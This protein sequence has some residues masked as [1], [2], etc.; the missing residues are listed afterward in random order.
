MSVEM[1]FA[2][3]LIAIWLTDYSS[4]IVDQLLKHNDNLTFENTDDSFIFHLTAAASFIY[5]STKK[6]C[7]LL[8]LHCIIQCN[9]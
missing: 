7:F 4:I 5:P 6:T 3:A 2:S 1:D 8:H 9:R